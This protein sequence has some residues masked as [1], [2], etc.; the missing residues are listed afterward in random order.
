MAESDQPEHSMTGCTFT[1]VGRSL[2]GDPRITGTRGFRTPRG[3]AARWCPPLPSAWRGP[4]KC[5]PTTPNLAS[6]VSKPPPSS[7]RRGSLPS[8]HSS[9]FPPCYKTVTRCDEAVQSLDTIVTSHDNREQGQE[10]SELAESRDGF[11]T[12]S[13]PAAA[14]AFRYP[15]FGYGS[16]HQ[17]P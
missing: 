7:T 5:R 17:C 13:R 8:P 4:H 1:P 10:W 3:L 14:S 12:A 15:R 16:A 2:L 6:R 9:A 11:L